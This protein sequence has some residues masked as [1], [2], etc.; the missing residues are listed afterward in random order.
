MVEAETAGKHKTVSQIVSIY[1]VLIFI[2]LRSFGTEGA[3]FWS[4]S[5]EMKLRSIIFIVMLITA[6]L[7]LASGIS[8]IMRNKKFFINAK[9]S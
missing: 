4:E 2:V 8:C 3:G 1:V 6:F 9:N 5:L 7:T